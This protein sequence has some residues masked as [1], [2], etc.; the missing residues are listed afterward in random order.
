MTT[1]DNLHEVAEL[2][3]RGIDA[4]MD[5]EV[6]VETPKY[7]PKRSVVEIRA[8]FETVSDYQALKSDVRDIVRRHEDGL[9]FTRISRRH[10]EPDGDQ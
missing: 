1:A 9:V 8:D 10:D 2:V 5:V 3:E 6:E 7:G 4:D